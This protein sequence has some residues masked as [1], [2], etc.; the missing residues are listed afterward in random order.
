MNV[1]HGML[2]KFTGCE[3]GV[4]NKTKQKRAN[5]CKKRRENRLWNV[6]YHGKFMTQLIGKLTS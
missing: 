2:Q 5:R 4:G 3:P 6:L 1:S